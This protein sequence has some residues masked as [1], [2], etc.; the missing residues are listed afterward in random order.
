MKKIILVLFV[1]AQL[2]TVASIASADAPWPTC[3]PCKGGVTS[4]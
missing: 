2:A 1:M 3:L 4:R